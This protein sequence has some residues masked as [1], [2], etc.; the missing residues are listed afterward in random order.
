MSR[1]DSENR[2]RAKALLPIHHCNSWIM[3]LS[4]RLKR[5]RASTCPFGHDLFTTP[6]GCPLR[7]HQ[8]LP[9]GIL[10]IPEKDPEAHQTKQLTWCEVQYWPTR[11]MEINRA[12][13]IL[14]IYNITPD[15]RTPSTTSHP[16]T[17]NYP[18]FPCQSLELERL[19]PLPPTT[20]LS[21]ES[22]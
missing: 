1:P 11:R 10:G 6:P 14:P 4:R 16:S 3:S 12:N 13:M 5:S 19:C 15:P 7:V 2:S 17:Y 18:T 20:P 22:Q 8:K 9:Q 21:V